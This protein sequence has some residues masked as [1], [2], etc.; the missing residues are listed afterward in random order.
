[1]FLGRHRANE[2][3]I[4]TILIQGFREAGVGSSHPVGK[5]GEAFGKISDAQNVSSERPLDFQ[6]TGRILP[7][8]DEKEASK[9]LIWG[10]IHI[11]LT[12]R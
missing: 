1:L 8:E 4:V 2:N 11:D 9:L 10:W 12:C 3:E 5:G 6:M 7:R